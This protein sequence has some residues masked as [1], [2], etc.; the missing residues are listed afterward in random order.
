MAEETQAL[1]PC[2]FCSGEAVWRE[3]DDAKP[4]DPFGLV[5]DHHPTCMF[6]LPDGREAWITAWNTRAALAPS[7]QSPEH[8]QK[9]GHSNP[10]WSAPSPLWNAVI[11]GGSI[12][13]EPKFDDMVCAACF[14]E[15]AEQQGIASDWS[16]KARNVAVPLETTTPSGRV[17]DDGKGLWVS[18]LSR[19]TEAVQTILAL[20][21]P[22][23][24]H[25]DTEDGRDI[26]SECVTQDRA[27][28]AYGDKSDMEIANAVFMVD[29]YDLALIHYQTA[30]K[31]R[32]RWLSAQLALA[33]HRLAAFQN[34]A[35]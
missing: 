14:M 1:L 16:V 29:R 25:W 28:I 17:W 5:V 4:Y 32:I 20:P 35:K 8:C 24:G 7:A 9:C 2:P 6:R 34:G 15:L 13:G 18:A 33:N 12:D 19:D 3:F 23:P 21:V 11:R 26:A 27:R 22:L 31:E 10:S 30:A